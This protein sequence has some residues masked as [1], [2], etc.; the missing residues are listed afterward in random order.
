MTADIKEKVAGV[1]NIDIRKLVAYAIAGAGMQYAS[2]YVTRRVSDEEM[3]ALKL[4]FRQW[5]NGSDPKEFYRKLFVK[6]GYRCEEVPNRWFVRYEIG[7]SYCY[8]AST[9]EL[10][11]PA[12]T[13]SSPGLSLNAADVSS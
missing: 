9:A 2:E 6:N 10:F 12:A 7:F 1:Q 3:D 5:L 4:Q 8:G 13:Y 11:C